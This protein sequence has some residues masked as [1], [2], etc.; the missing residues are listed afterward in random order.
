MSNRKT[1]WTRKF[2]I[3]RLKTRH[4]SVAQSLFLSSMSP[5][6][7][8]EC[9]SRTYT[10]FFLAAFLW[11]MKVMKWYITAK[12]IISD[13]FLLI[14]ISLCPLLFFCTMLSSFFNC[15]SLKNRKNKSNVLSGTSR[16]GISL[17]LHELWHNK[18]SSVTRWKAV[19]TAAIFLHLLCH[20]KKCSRWSF[21]CISR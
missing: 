18:Q 21:S 3:C 9:L 12:I 17:E 5:H 8:Y 1:I 10:H 19:V 2:K 11:V 20:R 16:P 4:R 15:Y 7:T 13:V 6:M 14:P